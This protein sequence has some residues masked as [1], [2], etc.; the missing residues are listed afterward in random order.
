MPISSAALERLLTRWDG[1]E[2]LY[3]MT[4]THPRLETIRLARNN[5]DVISRG[6]T[7]R[8]APFDLRLA[9]DN[10]ELPTLSVTIPNVDRAIGRSLMQIDT[11]MEVAIE[12][13]F[14]SN[15]DDVFKRYARLELYDVTFDPILVQGTISHRRITHEPFPN[16]R[17]IP[18]KFFAYYR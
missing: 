15:P 17:V 14:G 1:D 16:R 18:N 10:E 2:L 11:G 12:A 9:T 8:A 6:E 4:V 5:V 3:L 7:Y 13:V